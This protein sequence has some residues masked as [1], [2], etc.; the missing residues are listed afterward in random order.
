VTF[1]LLTLSSLRFFLHGQD[2]H[3]LP[4]YELLFNNVTHVALAGSAKDQQPI[5]LEPRS[6]RPVGF[7]RHEGMIPYDARS[8]LGYRLL[9]EYF[10]FPHKFRFFDLAGI[11][12]ARLAAMGGQL[13]IY[14][15]LD[16][17]ITDLER[18]VTADMFRMGCTPIINLFSKRAEPIK[19]TQTQFEYHIVP[20]ARRRAATEIHSINRVA[21]TSPQ[22][23]VREFQPFYSFRHGSDARQQKAFWY[24]TRRPA[25]RYK[26][27]PDQG[28]EV[29]LSLVDL[30][31]DPAAPADWVLDVETTCLNRDLPGQLHKPRLSLSEGGPISTV[32]CLVGPTPTRRPPRARGAIWRLLSHLVLNHLSISNLA[33]EGT[34]AG[35]GADALREILMLYDFA[36]AERVRSEVE[37]II[38]LTSRRVVG[39]VGGDVSGGFCRG[40]EVGIQFD[41][42]RFADHGVFLF[43]C[44]LERFLG[45]YASINSFSKLVATTKQREG[46]LKRW[47]PRTGEQ[48]LL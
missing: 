43:A 27:L 26:G 45:L 33:Q 47:A 1:D 9:T 25:E 39:R 12:P 3:V 30:E 29:Y 31:M 11:E 42:S 5:V 38:G 15:Y 34:S 40:I 7:E 10:T 36:G 46:V 19:I 4:L 35:G 44:V 37:S 18:N 22:D 24:A 17:T 2:Q 6:I 48:V 41:E 21:A 32:L 23:E 14:F 28:T 8:F 13:E 20:D 16:R